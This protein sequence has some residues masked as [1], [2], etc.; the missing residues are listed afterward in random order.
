MIVARHILIAVLVVLTLPWGAVLRVAEA[1]PAQ[2]LSPVVSV[3]AQVRADPAQVM[4]V[5]GH[6][7]RTA[8]FPGAICSFNALLPVDATAQRPEGQVRLTPVTSTTDVSRFEPA[9][10]TGPPRFV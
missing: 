7:C 8:V 3:E 5:S 4:R 2:P 10:D 9:P 1:G 6:K